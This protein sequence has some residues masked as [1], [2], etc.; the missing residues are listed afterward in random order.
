M[1]CS[2]V[3]DAGGRG[4]ILLV[5]RGTGEALGITLWEDEASMAASEERGNELPCEAAEEL[6]STE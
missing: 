2:G 1:L 4:A 5:N 3:R 6:G